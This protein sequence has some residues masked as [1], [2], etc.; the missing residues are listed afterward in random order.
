MQTPVEIVYQGIGSAPGI[1]QR[2]HGEVD[3]LERY[4][5]RITACRVVIEAPH[6]HQSKGKLFEVRVHLSV[7]GGDIAVGHGSDQN[8]AHEDPYVAVRQAFDAVRRQLEDRVRKQR[9][10]V[11]A[12]EVPPH[13]RVVRLFGDDGYG[14]IESS[15]GREIY[16]HRNSVVGDK[17]ASLE[18]GSEVR[19]SEEMG[20]EG[21][22]ASTVH[23][24]GKH[25]P[26]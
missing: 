5:D 23:I 19:F 13:G 17:F 11:K 4:H 6:R 7:P 14:F 25:H 10:K 22:Q 16:F 8:H 20:D 2:I 15:D 18:I 9:G 21:P 26:V 24:V 3:K 12:H 1:E